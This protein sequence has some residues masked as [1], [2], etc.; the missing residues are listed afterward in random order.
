[1]SGPLNPASWQYRTVNARAP[2]LSTMADT[3]NALMAIPNLI[4]LLLLS[5]VIFQLTRAYFGGTE[6][7]APIAET[8]NE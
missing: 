1:M 3:L 5:P 7:E 6:A 4:S 8:G 2:N